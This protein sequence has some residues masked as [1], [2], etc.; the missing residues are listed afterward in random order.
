M[1]SVMMR[2]KVDALGHACLYL[3]NTFEAQLGYDPRSVS[4][5][6]PVEHSQRRSIVASFH[7]SSQ[8]LQNTWYSGKT[9]TIKS[10]CTGYKGMV[11]Q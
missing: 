1:L 7:G 5:L 4:S 3:Y 6:R 11:S 8:W 2:V 10:Q 9:G